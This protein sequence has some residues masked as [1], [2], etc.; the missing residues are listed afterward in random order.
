VYARPG[1]RSPLLRRKHP[2]VD[3]CRL[4]NH[5][6]HPVSP[7][8]AD[9]GAEDRRDRPAALLPVGVDEAAEIRLCL[10]GEDG[11]QQHKLAYL[12]RNLRVGVDLPGGSRGDL[13]AERVPDKRDVPRAGRAADG[14]AVVID[15]NLGEIVVLGTLGHLDVAVRVLAEV[16]HATKVRGIPDAALRDDKVLEG[17]VEQAGG[18]KNHHVPARSDGNL[19]EIKVLLVAEPGAVGDLNVPRL[20][21]VNKDLGVPVAVESGNLRAG[22]GH[23]PRRIL[24]EALAHIE[25]D[26]RPRGIR[27]S[28]L[29]EDVL[30]AVSPKGPDGERNDDEQQRPHPPRLPPP[31]TDAILRN[32]PLPHGSGRPDSRGLGGRPYPEIL[33]GI[34]A[35]K[36]GDLARGVCC[37]GCREYV[38]LRT[39]WRYFGEVGGR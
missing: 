4:H 8:V 34:D 5:S 36:T 20:R 6:G 25:P 12:P 10:R 13:R 18:L 32:S 24:G 28:A 11:V 3:V 14:G 19:R 27:V 22:A 2:A 23:V 9:E 33:S 16:A 7:Q 15:E 39:G 1:G 38:V 31:H 30:L 21:T 35:R 29:V 26:A 37:M 17:D